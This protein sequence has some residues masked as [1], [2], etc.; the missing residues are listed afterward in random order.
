MKKKIHIFSYY[1]Q[2]LAQME[3]KLCGLD[4]QR[5]ALLATVLTKACLFRR[6]HT[7]CTT[8][9]LYFCNPQ[10]VQEL[11]V[12]IC[13]VAKK[14]GKKLR[15]LFDFVQTTAY[16]PGMWGKPY[17]EDKDITSFLNEVFPEVK[18]K[19]GVECALYTKLLPDLPEDQLYDKFVQFS[20]FRCVNIEV[21]PTLNTCEETAII[22]AALAELKDDVVL[23]NMLSLTSKC[24]MYA[25]SSAYRHYVTKIR[26]FTDGH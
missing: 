13:V 3:Q 11:L 5:A 19:S 12:Y 24:D 22:D 6:L 10:Y 16:S 1:L 21:L 17:V 8:Q 26:E 18:S 25:V 2:K 7:G 4:D 15:S 9:V 14:N 23:R 20:N